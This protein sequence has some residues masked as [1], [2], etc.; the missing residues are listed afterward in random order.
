MSALACGERWQ[1][2]YSIA[3]PARV[4]PLV[5]A[6]ATQWPDVLRLGRGAGR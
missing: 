5:S 6:S 4:A 3:S 1:H 2:W